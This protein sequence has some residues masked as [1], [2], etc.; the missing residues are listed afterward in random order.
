MVNSAPSCV[1]QPKVIN[2]YSDLIVQVFGEAGKHARSAVG[3]A[4]LP[5]NIPVEV[6][7]IAAVE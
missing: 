5:F 2:G 6:E 4:V 7:M 1:D 3:M